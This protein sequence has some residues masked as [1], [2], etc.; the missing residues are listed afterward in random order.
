MVQSGCY[1]PAAAG[2]EISVYT[3][4]YT[5]IGDEQS[6]ENDLSTYSSH[7]M[8]MKIMMRHATEHTLILIDE[9]GTGTEPQI[10]GAI[11]EAVLRQFWKKHV[12]AVITTHYQNLKHFAENHPGT[13]NGAMLY[14][15]HEMRPLFQLAIGRPGSSFAIEIARKTGIPEEVI[16][17]AADIVGSDYIQS[18]KYLQDIVRDK[19]YW[20]SK[21][22]TIH[23]HEKE[24]EKRIAQYEK[25]IAT[26]EQSRKDI[27][28][29]AKEQAEEIIKESNRRIENTIREIRE[30]QAEKEET[31]RIR[32][33]LAAYE[34]GLLSSSQPDKPGKN[35]KKKMKDS[36]LLSDEDFQKKVDKIKSR[37]ERHE[38][39]L[40]E[41]AGKQQAAAE[42]LKN[43]VRKQQTG[44]VVNVG[45]AVRIKGLTTIGKVEAIDGKQATVIF[46]DMRTKMAVSRLEHVDAAS[47]QTEQQQFQAYNYSRETRETIDKH[48][49]QF[50][51]ELDVRGMRADEALNQVQYFIDDAIL[52]GAGQ[53]RILHGKGNGIL[54]QLIRQYLA[55]IPNVKS[56]RD[57]HVQFGGA[58]ITVVEL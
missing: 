14:D 21:R 46:G 40:K 52:V 30:K 31:K 12:W 22:Q 43:A 6:I 11:A 8:N 44:G 37:K 54:R 17:D 36:G 38:Q 57:E 15:R 16:H 34:E 33:K 23:S 58:G 2:S 39:H 10:G 55:S 7:L 53:V 4:V 28:R 18:D 5:V 47:L 51:Q 3:N 26:L 48:R 19:R 29:R 25:D 42:A 20:E 27:L 32:Q 49:N 45:D 13:A 56:Y 24:L 41:R 9:F 50:H 1:I 35:N